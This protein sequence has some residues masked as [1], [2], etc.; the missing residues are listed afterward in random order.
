MRGLSGN[1][2]GIILMVIATASFATNDALLKLAMAEVP[3]FQ[4]LFIRGIFILLVG[5]PV[6]AAMGQL[7]FLP[8]VFE[9]R[10]QVRNLFELLAAMGFVIG[11]AQAP[12]ADLTALAQTSPLLLLAG[13]ML[14]LGERLTRLQIAL[15]L[16]AFVGALLVAQPGGGNFSPYVLFG[17]WSAVGV[18]IR[19]LV[20]RSIGVEIPGLVIALGAGIIQIFGAGLG[21]ALF[22]TWQWPSLLALLFILGSSVFIVCGHW[23]LLSAYRAAT[24]GA[25]APFLY[26]SSIWALITGAVV[27]GTTPNVIA[28]VGIALIVVSGVAVVALERWPR[29]VEPAP[30]DN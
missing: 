20:G 16:L 22:E 7:R 17:L 12:I 14:F 26:M 29:G 18:A 4:S 1:S 25:V 5:I 11:L 15:G 24:V 6:L 21:T 19:D 9:R 28:F 3:P 30:V 2:V 8:R 27:F 23:L 10:V 13:A